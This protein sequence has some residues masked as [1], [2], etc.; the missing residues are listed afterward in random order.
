MKLFSRPDFIGIGGHRCGSTWLSIQ[1]REHPDVFMPPTKE[2][3]FFSRKW[4]RKW[5]SPLLRNSTGLSRAAY[6]RY[7]SSSEAKGKIK[8]EITP[9][10]SILLPS[11]ISKIKAVLPEVKIIYV[12][13][14]PVD[15]VWSHIRKDYESATGRVLLE[16]TDRMLIDFIR[17]REVTARTEYSKSLENWLQ[18]YG[19]ESLYVFQYEDIRSDPQGMINTVYS[20]LGL[21]SHSVDKEILKKRV[22]TFP[23]RKEMPEL[24]REYVIEEFY[25]QKEELQT[26]LGQKILWGR[27]DAKA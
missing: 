25:P 23:S 22:N 1:L 24:V 7:F 5:Y 2:L 21:R 4:E 27:S 9:A 8:G 14:D 26:L 18:V 13:R 17:R 16:A 6:A 3:Q 15:R 11:N 19:E 12:I 20:F 10:Y